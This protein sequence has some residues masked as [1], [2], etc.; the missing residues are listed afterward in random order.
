MTSRIL[1][2]MF[3]RHSIRKRHHLS[4]YETTTFEILYRISSRAILGFT[5]DV[6]VFISEVKIWLCVDVGGDAGPNLNLGN[7]PSF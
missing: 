2:C 1:T 6:N 7:I 3:F 4:T 5:P